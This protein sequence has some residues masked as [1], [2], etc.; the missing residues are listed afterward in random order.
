VYRVLRLGD[1][2]RVFVNA[3]QLTGELLLIVSLSFALGWGLAN[4]HVPEALA[5]G[6]DALVIGDS[7]FLRILSMVILAI[8]AGMVLDPLIPVLLPIILPTLLAYRIDLIHFGVLMA[9]GDRGDHRAGHAAYGDRLGHHRSDRRRRS[10]A[11]VPRQSAVPLGH[12]R[13]PAADHGRARDRHL[14]AEHRARLIA[15]RRQWS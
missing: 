14:A 15:G 5:R 13:V 3:V 2:Y 10:A 8:V 9:H 7:R 1:L 6:I 11:R 12:A 4:A